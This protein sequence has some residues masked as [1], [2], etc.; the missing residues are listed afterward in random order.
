M[1]N[2]EKTTFFE[3]LPL[4]EDILDALY[5]MRFETCT[6]IQA[7]CIPYILEGK[8]IVGIAQTGTGKTAAYLLPL[9]TLLQQKPR[10]QNSIGCLIMAP[11]RELA[12]QIDQAL[13]GFG[14]YTNTTGIAVYGGNDGVRFEQERRSMLTGADIII[15]TP[16]RLLTHLDLGHLD[17]SRTQYLVL[18][19]ADRMLDMGFIDDI[20]R[21]AS[22]LPRMRQTI[23]FSATM[24]EKIETLAKNLMNHP[25][26]V[27]IAVS[28]PV[29]AIRQGA[30]ICNEADKVKILKHIFKQ[31]PPQR[32]IVFCSSKQKV[33]EL[34][35]LLASQP[36]KVET[37]HSDLEQRERDNVMQQFKN[38]HI[39]LLVATDIVARG[40]DV[41]D[42]DMVINYDVPRH[43]EEY[44]HRIGRT[45]RAGRGGKAYTLVNSRDIQYWRRI[46]KLLKEH[47]STEPLPEDCTPPDPKSLRSD[48]PKSA[49]HR[50][51][52]KSQRP[53]HQTKR[54]SGKP[55]Q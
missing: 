24:P 1:N 6:P 42:I 41:N 36:F 39:P 7:S 9:L 46:E 4:S 23:L 17:L 37:M 31:T 16:G 49:S 28:K 32:A 26:E 30:F 51:H 54:K 50:R 18:D 3:E 25:V 29:E 52:R 12:Q 8:D 53:K 14:Y 5:D 38:G 21:I 2:D 48:C 27:K 44:V 33:K 43:P 55:T 45:A 11:T 34:P 22:Q 35:R 10:P 19:E 20:T 47:I 13:Q 40:I 15:A